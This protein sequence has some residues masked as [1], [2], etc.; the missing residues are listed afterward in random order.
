[1]P[2]KKIREMPREVWV[3]RHA[4]PFSFLVWDREPLLPLG[5]PPATKYVRSDLTKVA[6]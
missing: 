2:R 1:M 3:V 6:P 4:G 5:D